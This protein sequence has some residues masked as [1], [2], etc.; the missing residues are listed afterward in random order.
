MRVL[1]LVLALSAL[2]ACQPADKPAAKPATG[3]A[4]VPD[5]SGKRLSD[6]LDAL[7]A[8]GFTKVTSVDGSGRGR[9]VVVAADWTVQSQ[10]PA[11]GAAAPTSDVI[12]LTVRK[13]T[14]TGSSAAPAAGVVPDVTCKNLQDAQDTLQAAGYRDLGSEDALGQGRA[15]LLDRDW[16]VVKQ[17]VA[18]GTKAPADTRVVLSAVKY[19]ES[20]GSSGCTS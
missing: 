4:G 1:A 15:Q 7:H 10:Q 3:S 2:V 14:D 5:V 12:T 9:V 11:A 6:A 8:A 17:S 20:T 13:P 18:A 19:G 16:L